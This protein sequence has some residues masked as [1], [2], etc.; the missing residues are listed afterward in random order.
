LKNT[1]LV[2]LSFIIV[3]FG[4][5]AW[6]PYLGLIAATIGY[7]LF[8]KVLL[9]IPSNKS[10]FWLGTVWFMGIQMIQLSWFISHPYLY[11]YI[12]WVVLSFLFSLPFGGICLLIKPNKIKELSTLF[13]IPALWVL[14]EWSKLF[15]LSGFSWNPVGMA[16]VGSLY[17]LQGASIGGIF[18]LSFWV[19][20][21]NILALRAWVKKSYVPWVLA[22]MAPYFFGVLHF[23]Y[24]EAQMEK[25]TAKNLN[26]VLVQTAFPVEEAMFFESQQHLVRFV[27]N[28]WSQILKII[29][30]HK[31]RS[32][33][34]IALPEFVVPFG[35]YTFV[36]TYEEVKEAFVSVFGPES[37]RAL[38]PKETPFAVFRDRTWMVNNAFWAQGISNLFNSGLVV[39]LEDVDDLPSGEREY[40]SSA[41]YFEPYQDP[42][43]PLRYAKRVLV[44]MGE[45]IPFSF[46]KDLAAKYGICGSFTCGKEAVAWACGTSKFG[47]SIC[48][49]ETFGHLMRESK[50]KG[51]ELL[52][53]I[54]SDAWYP[55]SRLPK[56]HLEHARLRTVENG[57]PLVRACNT[58]ITV[59]IDSLGRDVVSLGLDAADPESVSDSLFVSVPSF[60]Y[61]TIYTIFGDWLIVGLSLIILAGALMLRWMN[62]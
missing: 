12:L 8:W 37:E 41:L 18:G 30:K 1:L 48:Y 11:I 20:F 22:C 29:K 32:I 17:A 58:G 7:A 10:R 9:D 47:V 62:D 34:L 52:L 61:S 5:P 51:A 42:F 21:T 38:P 35:T 15:I 31:G 49:E 50:T 43:M 4:Q 6:H 56:Q 23:H 14:F 24:Y 3:A 19:L 13:V 39:G 28:E 16:L 27:M 59:A 40:Y 45:Y 36:F 25:T 33:D 2:I 60:H 57:F 46:C 55:Q 54:T 44:P 26:V 53:N